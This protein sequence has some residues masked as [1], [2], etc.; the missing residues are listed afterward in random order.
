MT[1]KEYSKTVRDFIK[2]SK[3][4]IIMTICSMLFAL[5]FSLLKILEEFTDF[6]VN[7]PFLYSKI[8]TWIMLV[9]FLAPFTFMIISNIKTRK[10]RKLIEQSTNCENGDLNEQSNSDK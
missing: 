1:N 7:F 4:G 10:F 5:F 6:E 8:F 2:W 9:V 3:I